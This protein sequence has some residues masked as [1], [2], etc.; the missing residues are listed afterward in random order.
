M[1]W[2]E[3]ITKQKKKPVV[4]NVYHAYVDGNVGSREIMD[5]ISDQ[6]R[7]TEKAQ[8][9]SHT[10][11][12]FTDVLLD[13]HQQYNGEGRRLTADN[14]MYQAIRRLLDWDDSLRTSLEALS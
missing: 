7:M 6:H 12:A 5:V 4:R 11:F 13:E 10:A 2:T 1:S 14:P 8:A 9:N 3:F